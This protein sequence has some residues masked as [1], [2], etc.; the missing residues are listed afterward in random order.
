MGKKGEE[1]ENATA[2]KKS[3]LAA[4]ETQGS[5]RNSVGK[6]D[7]LNAVTNHKYQFIRILQSKFM[8]FSIL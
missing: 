1:K 7:D 4:D 6:V 2:I 8:H 5:Q 3:C